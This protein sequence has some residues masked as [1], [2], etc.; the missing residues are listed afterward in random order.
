M[1]R[2]TRTISALTFVLCFAL[3][4]SHAS[5]QTVPD[6]TPLQLKYLGAAGWQIT[7]GK[8]VVLVDTYISRIKYSGPGDPAD[9]RPNNRSTS[10]APN[11]TALIYRLIPRADFILL[12]HGHPD[13]LFDNFSVHVVPSI[14][15]ALNGN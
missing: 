5:P 15:S 13:H 2:F 7:D 3:W 4:P 9:T 11:D 1:P 8:V 12:H 14:H 6:R 10:V